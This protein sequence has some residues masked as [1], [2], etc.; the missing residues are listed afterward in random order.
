MY[1]M[2]DLWHGSPPL[3]AYLPRNS[4]ARRANQS[5]AEPQLATMDG[6]TELWLRA[7]H[8][9]RRIVDEE[10]LREERVWPCPR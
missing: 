10:E 2:Y 6:H 3:R 9:R 7:V 1:D 5:V 8:G 4:G